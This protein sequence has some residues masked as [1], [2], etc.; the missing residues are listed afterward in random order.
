MPPMTPR[1]L[2]LDSTPPTVRP[3]AEDEVGPAARLLRLLP[4]AAAAAAWELELMDVV[5]EDEAAEVRV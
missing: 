3:T 4:V 5:D 2:M 1:P